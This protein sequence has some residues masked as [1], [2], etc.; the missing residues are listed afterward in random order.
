M[1]AHTHTHTHTRSPTHL[2]A[3]YSPRV[4]ARRGSAELSTSRSMQLA[5]I[6]KNNTM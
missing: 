4:Q 1:P 2:P 6:Y 3:Q 5:I